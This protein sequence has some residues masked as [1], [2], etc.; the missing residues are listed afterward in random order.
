MGAG[1]TTVGA[2]LAEAIG[3][4]FVDNDAGIEAEYDATGAELADRLGVEALHRIEAQQLRGAIEWFDT[5]P[6]VIAA[7]ASVID[8]PAS[9]ALLQSRTTVWLD[10]PPHYLAGRLS[11]A[12]HR[13]KL[14]LDPA[15]A[16]ADQRAARSEAFGSVA[17]IVV[18]VEGR[19]TADI[20]D[21]IHARLLD[22][23]AT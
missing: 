1:K 19:S 12:T 2:A 3:Y 21:E 5:E 4:R 23:A 8:N 7:A 18:A 11:G 16:L 13:R 6:V 17:D 20:V 14:G 9:R 10:A 22:P 15:R